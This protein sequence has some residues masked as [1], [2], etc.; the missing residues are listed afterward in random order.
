MVTSDKYQNIKNKLKSIWN[1]FAK[2]IP[3]RVLLNAIDSAFDEIVQISLVRLVFI[4]TVL[5]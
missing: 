5:F 2:V 1:I 3:K 4:E